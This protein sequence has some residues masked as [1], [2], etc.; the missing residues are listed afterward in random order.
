MRA[1]YA[2]HILNVKLP[3]QIFL[4]F[5]FVFTNLFAHPHSENDLE[6]HTHTHNQNENDLYR[7]RGLR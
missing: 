2:V 1:L 6:E 3:T 5:T 7:S 4:L